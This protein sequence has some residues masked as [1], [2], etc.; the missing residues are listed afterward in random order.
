MKQPVGS[1]GNYPP[2]S[3]DHGG[4][5]S[6]GYSTANKAAGGQWRHRRQRN[7]KCLTPTCLDMP[8]FKT[9]DP[10]MDIMYTIWKF[11]ME[12]WLYQYDEASMMPHIY[13]SLQGY[14][15]KW[16]HSLEEGQNIFVH[17]LLRQMDTTFR[18]IQFYDQVLV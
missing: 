13:H 1:G 18:S 9:I 5:D 4:A 16:V 14:P 2:S 10:N 12:G 11:D 7:E 6:D 3:P 15:G 8:S 17:D